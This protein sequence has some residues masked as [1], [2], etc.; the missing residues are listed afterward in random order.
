MDAEELVISFFE[1][2]YNQKDFGYAMEIY[3]DTYYEHRESGARCN[4]DC[5]NIIKGASSIFPDLNVEINEI[6]SK[7]DIVAVRLTFTVTHQGEFFGIPATNKTIT[8]E[9]MEFF[10]VLAG[11]ITE[12]WG[13][14]PIYD[15]LEMLKK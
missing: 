7:N 5:Y 2:V 10:K 11:K 14:W 15:I 3:A 1:R 4:Q 8:F 6:L 12:S 13:S 9:A